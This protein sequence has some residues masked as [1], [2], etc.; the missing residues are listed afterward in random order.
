LSSSSAFVGWVSESPCFFAK[1]IQRGLG[2]LSVIYFCWMVVQRKKKDYFLHIVV[3]K[4]QKPSRVWWF[5]Q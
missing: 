3:A 1:W 4:P 2:F 5:C